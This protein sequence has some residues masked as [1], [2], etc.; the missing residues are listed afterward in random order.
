MVKHPKR[1]R[2][3]PPQF[4]PFE[5]TTPIGALAQGD[6]VAVDSGKTVQDRKFLLYHKGTWGLRNGT[7]GEGPI[8]FGL[9][10]SDLSAA[11]IEEYLENT[12]GWF[13]SDIIAQLVN[14]RGRWIKRVGSFPLVA[15]DEVL[16]NGNPKVTRL[17]FAVNEDEGLGVWIRNAS[18]AI[19]TTGGNITTEG[20]VAARRR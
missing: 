12:A 1:G 19:L 17:G 14:Q 20:F 8:T 11:E 9:A 4:L 15:A 5:N 18:G 6:V 10:H 7:P 3:R 16:N 13:E 2:R